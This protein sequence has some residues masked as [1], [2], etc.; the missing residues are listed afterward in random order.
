MPP[1]VDIGDGV[2]IS[3]EALTYFARAG[4]VESQCL[5]GWADDG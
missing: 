1:M 3:V 2:Q 5:L 4:D